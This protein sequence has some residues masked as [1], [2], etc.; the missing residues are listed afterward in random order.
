M[1]EV[2]RHRAILHVLYACEFKNEV[3]I[4]P[5]PD[6][7]ANSIFSVLYF[8]RHHV[9][10]R[11]W[12]LLSTAPF[13]HDAILVSFLMSNRNETKNLILGMT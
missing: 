8:P 11:R 9:I 4:T 6:L 5:P 2:P 3:I 10:L 12:C 7:T 13:L 1:L